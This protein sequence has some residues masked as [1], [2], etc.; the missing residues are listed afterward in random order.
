[1]LSA[2][3]VLVA[4]DRQL[5]HDLQTHFKKVLGLTA[6]LAPLQTAPNYLGGGG[7][8]MLL[9]AVATRP[10]GEYV[11]RLLHET[12]PGRL[13]PSLVILA[14][15]DHF[16]AGD[17]A[18]LGQ[19]GVRTMIWPQEQATFVD[20]LSEHLAN[21]HTPRCGA[22]APLEEVIRRRLQGQTPS[23]AHLA[24][25]LAL[26][27]SHDLTVLLTGETGTGKTFLARLI[28]ELSPRHRHRLLTV[29]C[30]ALVAGLAESEFFGHAKGAF[31]GADRPKVGKFEAAGEGTILLDEIDALGLEQ[32]ANLLRVVETGEYE[33]VGSNETRLCKAR[34]IAASHA[35]I[36]Q[37]VERGEFRRDLFY[38]LNVISLYLPALRER[39]SDVFHLARH[40]TD[41]FCEKFGKG[42]LVIRPETIAALQAFPWP[43]NVRQ[44]ENAIQQAVLHCDAPELAPEHLPQPVRD[45]LSGPSTPSPRVADR[46]RGD[47]S[48]LQSRELL[49]RQVIK[50]ALT[51]HGY[52]RVQAANALGVSRVTLYKK[53]KK[54]GLMRPPRINGHH[55]TGEMPQNGDPLHWLETPPQ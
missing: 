31:T 47:T 22:E 9:V 2:R 28:H 24:G 41:K 18:R 8:D 44:L 5:T 34:I 55:D 29:P 27:A 21:G 30:G 49:E 42:P 7:T 38:R 50:Q 25:H 40:L 16:Q 46:P 14:G 4:D 54:Y 23:L 10:E 48:L 53:M 19:L 3:L 20:L 6:P 11:L 52:S 33:P 13:P 12:P 36:A 39:V 45:H 32:Q 35:D 1:M 17:L 37:K 51:T 26:A 43:G 15:K